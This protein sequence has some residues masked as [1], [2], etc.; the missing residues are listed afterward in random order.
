MQIGV[1]KQT[2]LKTR[3]FEDHSYDG[4]SDVAVRCGSNPQLNDFNHGL[5]NVYQIVTHYTGVKNV[6]P[7][8]N[9]HIF[10][11]AFKLTNYK[12]GKLIKFFMKLLPK[13]E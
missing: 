10:A 7:R 6:E 3:A 11:H 8:K 12:S 1:S 9:V 5:I 4:C 2:S 13:R